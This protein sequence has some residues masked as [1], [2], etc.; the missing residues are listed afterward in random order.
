MRVRVGQFV[1]NFMVQKDSKWRSES[2][3]G[4]RTTFLRHNNTARR[5]A[6]RG[7]GG[8]KGTGARGCIPS[9]KIDALCSVLF[10]TVIAV[11]T[12]VGAAGFSDTFFRSFFSFPLRLA[13]RSATQGLDGRG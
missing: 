13:L 7:G 5:P 6:V 10:G 3:R 2:I 12:E 4:T 9:E 1:V 11:Y 8:W